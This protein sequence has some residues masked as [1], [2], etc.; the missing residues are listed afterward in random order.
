MNDEINI[1]NDVCKICKMDKLCIVI[2]YDENTICLY[3]LRELF[4]AW[5]YNDCE[6]LDFIGSEEYREDCKKG[7]Y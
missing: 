6:R 2:D 3:C 5:D 7:C 1:R 4:D